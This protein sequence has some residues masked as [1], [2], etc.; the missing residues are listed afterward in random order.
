[1]YNTDVE[2]MHFANLPD[3]NK[4]TDAHCKAMWD[5][6]GEASALAERRVEL[7]CPDTLGVKPGES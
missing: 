6:P 5:C 7:L 1:V 3:A 2:A 4:L